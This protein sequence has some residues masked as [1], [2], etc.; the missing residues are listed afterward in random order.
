MIAKA[1]VRV[2][3][4]PAHKYMGIYEKKETKA[5][6][7]WPGHDCDLVTSVVSNFDVSDPIVTMNTAGWTWK[8][9]KRNYFFG[10]GLP[11]DYTGKIPEGFELRECPASYYLVFSYP[12][13]VYPGENK[14]A[15][16][17]VE[18]MAWSFDP[19]SM[20]YAW[21]EDACQD[22][23]RHYPEGLGY[24]VLRPVKKV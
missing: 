19:A 12:P 10:G 6:T 24:Q 16:E 8:D 3:Y 9:G 20:G 1:T 22:Y 18:K 13:F 2:E 4:S 17:T 21:N 5:G 14:A 11:L 7:M 23:Q 15:M